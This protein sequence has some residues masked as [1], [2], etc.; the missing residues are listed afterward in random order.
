[1]SNRKG[2]M[3]CITHA[4]VRILMGKESIPYQG[5]Q[6]FNLY[7]LSAAGMKLL[8]TLAAESRPDRVSFIIIMA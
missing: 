7:E 2:A 4:M 6:L 5:S 8:E 1:M 3:A